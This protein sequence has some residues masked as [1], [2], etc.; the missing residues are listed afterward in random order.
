MHKPHTF[1]FVVCGNDEHIDCLHY[2]MN[3]LKMFSVNNIVV[4]TDSKRNSRQINHD[5]IIQVDTPENFNNHQASIYMKTGLHRFLPNGYLYCYLDSDV[6]AVNSTVDNIFLQYEAPITFAPDHCVIDEFSPHAVNCNCL[7]EY[8]SRV[9]SFREVEAEFNL[10]HQ[11]EYDR[12]K[13]EIERITQ[14]NKRNFIVHA[15]SILRYYLA[16]R[17]Y[18]ISE[19]LVWDKQ[20]KLW[21]NN[22]GESIEFKYGLAALVTKQL[23]LNWSETLNSYLLPDG[24][25]FFELSCS[26]LRNEVGKVFGVELKQNNWQHWNGGVFLFDDRSHD[27]LDFWHNATLKIFELPEWKTRDQ[28]TLIATV[29]KFGLQHHPMLS[30]MFNY[31]VDYTNLHQ[32]YKG[33]LTFSDTKHENITPYFVHVFHHFGDT[34]WNVW[35]DIDKHL[36]SQMHQVK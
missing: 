11:P 31:I 30:S 3:A 33:N 24:K 5:K 15:F 6:I 19:D 20:Y 18:R 28:G 17:Y 32:Q 1:V 25:P 23:N 12:I 26:H 21:R 13:S 2:S 22:T 34:S 29:W 36:T 9:Q 35:Q 8:N 10:N 7:K 16:G 4:V 14:H 27:F